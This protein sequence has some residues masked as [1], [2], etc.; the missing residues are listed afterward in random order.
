MRTFKR[1]AY[2]FSPIWHEAKHGSANLDHGCVGGA[3]Y[4][5]HDSGGAVEIAATIGD[6]SGLESSAPS[7]P[8][9]SWMR[10]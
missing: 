9:L 4:P 2:I 3:S 1:I 7:S 6:Q 5:R 8:L 10:P